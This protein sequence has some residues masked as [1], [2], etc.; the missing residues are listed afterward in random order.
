MFA[1]ELLQVLLEQ[2]IETRIALEECFPCTETSKKKAAISTRG[3]DVS[4]TGF[5]PV[6]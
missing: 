6:F 1:G 4:P 5:E 3:G 2:G